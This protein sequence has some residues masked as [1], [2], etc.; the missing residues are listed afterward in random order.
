MEK[1]AQVFYNENYAEEDKEEEEKKKKKEK[2]NHKEIQIF[3][4]KITQDIENCDIFTVVTS[5]AAMKQIQKINNKINKRIFQKIKNNEN[6]NKIHNINNINNVIQNI[7][8]N[9]ENNKNKIPIAKEIEQLTIIDNDYKITPINSNEYLKIMKPNNK[10]SDLEKK[11]ITTNSISLLI[12]ELE[13]KD[14]KNKLNSKNNNMINKERNIIKNINNNCIVIQGGKTTNN[15]NINI[16]HLT[17]G[18]KLIPHND[19]NKIIN[20]LALLSN[21]INNN[22][23]IIKKLKHNKNNINNS[24]N[25]KEKNSNINISNNKENLP[26]SGYNK[27]KNKNSS[28]TLPPPSQNVLS[29]I[30]SNLSKKYNQIF[31]NTINNFSIK[32][33]KNTNYKSGHNSGSITSLNKYIKFGK[34]NFPNQ[35]TGKNTLYINKSNYMKN[36]FNNMKYGTTKMSKKTNIAYKKNIDILSGE[37]TRSVSNMH[38]KSKRII[39]STL[40]FNG[41]NIQLLNMKNYDSNKNQENRSNS[42]NKRNAEFYKINSKKMI[43]KKKE[44]KTLNQLKVKDLNIKG[45]HLNFQKILNIVPKN[46]RAKSTGK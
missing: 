36:F 24:I 42:T 33:I 38:K 15:I 1:V 39:Y 31:P 6:N 37:R 13:Q 5:E 10:I 46:S 22:K 44:E 45:K 26:L 23:K 19:N 17:I 29:S 35:Q 34:G 14:N 41:G 40:H 28:L 27:D 32:Q 7:N 3:S 4:K 12:E 20:G 30:N 16:N 11:E 8:S 25:N 43:I 2:V 21:K 18:Q 9:L